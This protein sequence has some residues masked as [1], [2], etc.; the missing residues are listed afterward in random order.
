MKFPF[1]AKFK[2]R[3]ETVKWVGYLDKKQLMNIYISLVE[4][5]FNL[6]DLDR[7]VE[8]EAEKIGGRIGEGLKG[9][10][11]TLKEIIRKE[12]KSGTKKE[13]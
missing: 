13:S 12:L 10:H 2:L 6:E 11:K 7:F 4:K 5:A 3:L 1:R 8:E 9:V